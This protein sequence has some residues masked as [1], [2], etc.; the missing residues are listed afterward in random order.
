MKDSRDCEHLR[1]LCIDTVTCKDCGTQV[2]L[3]PQ[4]E[5]TPTSTEALPA[6]IKAL[7]WFPFGPNGSPMLFLDDVLALFAGKE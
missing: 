6:K 1:L 7:P 4:G 3:S 2:V 5:L